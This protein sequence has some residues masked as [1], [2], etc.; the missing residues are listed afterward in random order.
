MLR[1]LNLLSQSAPLTIGDLSRILTIPYGTIHQA[2]K[3]DSRFTVALG[4]WTV[5]RKS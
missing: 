2:I 5:K 4:K 1:C 3:S